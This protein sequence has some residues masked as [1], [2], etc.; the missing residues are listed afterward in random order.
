MPLLWIILLTLALSGFAIQFSKRYGRLAFP[1]Q[2]N[3]SNYMVDAL[4]RLDIVMRSSLRT[5]VRDYRQNPPH[6]PVSTGIALTSFVLFGVSESS[7]YILNAVTLL[8]LLGLILFVLRHGTLT[9]KMCGA[10]LAATTHLAFCCVYEFEPDYISA[11]FTMWGISVFFYHL[12]ENSSPRWPLWLSGV[13]FGLALISKVPFFPYTLGLIMFV[14]SLKGLHLMSQKGERAARWRGLLELWPFVCALAIVAG[15]HYVFAARRAWGYIFTNITG[16]EPTWRFGGFAERFLFYLNGPPAKLYLGSVRGWLWAFLLLGLAAAFLPGGKPLRKQLGYHALAALLAYIF[17]LFLHLRST[18]FG[19]PFEVAFLLSAV[20]AVEIVAQACGQLFRKP[21]IGCLIWALLV[22]KF[23]WRFDP[24]LE[25]ARPLPQDRNET[26]FLR[27]TPE[28][29][30]LAVAANLDHA[31]SP[32]V[33]FAMNGPFLNAQMVEW[34]ALRERLYSKKGERI[35]CWTAEKASASQILEQSKSA[36]FFVTADPDILGM[37]RQTHPTNERGPE[38]L[39]LLAT[40]RD[41]LPL[42]NFPAPDGQKYYLYMH[43]AE[44]IKRLNSK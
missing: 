27:D 5:A 11:V 33:Y 40:N 29:L 4:K 36:G 20:I 21:W 13:F 19:V 35:S 39:S 23:L 24:P 37:G 14:L 10:L 34:L 38:L 25:L 6:S 30:T 9:A 26:S 18:A 32:A 1:P 42:T 43:P 8:A 22:V 12:L 15:P 3:D 7:P 28:R 2:Y 17:L 31:F 44:Q 16:A 41:F